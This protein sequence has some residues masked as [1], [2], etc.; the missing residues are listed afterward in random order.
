MRCSLKPCSPRPCNLVD[1]QRLDEDF[2]QTVLVLAQGPWTPQAFPSWA[3]FVFGSW[4]LDLHGCRVQTQICNQHSRS[5]ASVIF[6]WLSLICSFRLVRGRNTPPL[7]D[8]RPHGY[9]PGTPGSRPGMPG[10]VRVRQGMSRAQVH[11]GPE[12][13]RKPGTL[14]YACVCA[15][16]GAHARHSIPGLME[17]LLVAFAPC[18]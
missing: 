11:P 7:S 6:R 12:T 13:P 3:G 8:I 10:Y 9:A 14:R 16:R 2:L 18:H 17:Q 4:V 5:R 15:P 1:R